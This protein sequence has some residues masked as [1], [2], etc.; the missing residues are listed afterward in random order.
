MR[1]IVLCIYIMLQ[2]LFVFSCEKKYTVD[3][4]CDYTT[5]YFTYS[6]PEWGFNDRYSKPR[7]ENEI[8]SAS[9][10]I[11]YADSIMYDKSIFIGF[12]DDCTYKIYEVGYDSES[13]IW[14]ISYLPFPNDGTIMFGGCFRIYFKAKDGEVLC[15]EPGE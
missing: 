6:E 9:D 4:T 15:I 2:C 8:L 10:A 7:S 12:R 1:R 11:T 14:K 3:M 13:G 5:E